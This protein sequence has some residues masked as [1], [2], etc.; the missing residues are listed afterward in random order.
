MN[1]KLGRVPGH[2]VLQWAD[3]IFKKTKH[4]QI[5]GLLWELT[6]VKCVVY[7]QRRQD[8]EGAP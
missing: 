5:K 6:S 3:F 4:K 2:S 7:K 1:L 8:I